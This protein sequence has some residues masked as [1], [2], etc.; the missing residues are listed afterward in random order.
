MRGAAG[1]MGAGTVV[2]RCG[3]AAAAAAP[4]APG[5]WT[6]RLGPVLQLLRAAAGQGLATRDVAAALGAPVALLAVLLAGYRLRGH[7]WSAGPR[8]ALRWFASLQ[9]AQ[10]HEAA[11]ALQP[12][13]AVPAVLDAAAALVARA[14]DVTSRAVAAALV[15]R[16]YSL[17]MV[18]GAVRR[19]VRAGGLRAAGTVPAPGSRHPLTVYTLRPAA[20]A[21]GVGGGVDAGPPQA[22]PWALLQGWLRPAAQAAG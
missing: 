4:V 22:A 11:L 8:H 9:A 14:A 13:E 17:A 20:G 3:G 10:A 2:H 15:P 1:G 6:R 16:G 21:A 7:V 12:P 5:G 19:V 18:L